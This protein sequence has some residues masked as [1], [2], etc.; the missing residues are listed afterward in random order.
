MSLN[1]VARQMGLICINRNLRV[2]ELLGLLIIAALLRLHSRKK[3]L[4]YL[5]K[6]TNNVYII[7]ITQLKELQWLVH[8]NNENMCYVHTHPVN[9]K[10]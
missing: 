5:D 2:D 4:G 8:T 7:Q 9:K 10:V 1:S 3:T 6:W